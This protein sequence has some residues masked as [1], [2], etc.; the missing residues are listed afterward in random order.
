LPQETFTA[1][2]EDLAHDGR[3]IARLEGK[4]VLVDGALPGE[5]VTFRYTVRHSGYDEGTV[6]T[7]L[8]PAA[9]R[10]EP[11]CTHFGVCGGCG[12][13]HLEPGAQIRFKEAQLLDNLRRIGKVQPQGVLPP[14][15][16]D[17]WGYR[18]KARLGVK[19]V[20]KKGRVLVGFRERASPYIAAL[21]RCEVLHPRVGELLEPLGELI[22]GL[23]IYNRLPQIEVAVGDNAV[24]LSF[25]VLDPPSQSDCQLLTAFGQRHDIWIY[26][27]PKGPETT[28]LLWP[29]KG[30][31]VYRLSGL[32]LELA[33]QPYHFTQVN[34]AIN[35]SMIQQALELLD[36]NGRETVLDLFCGLGNFTLPLAR[37]AARVVGVEGD[38]SL[39][40]WA[41][42]N[43][44]RNAIDN[45]QFYSA[46]LTASPAEQ[47]W[48]KE[49]F[50]RVLLDPPRSGA[51]EMIPTLARLKAERIVYVSCHP[52]T[53]ARDAG[54][55]VNC[56]GYR[57]QRAGV[58]DMFPHTAH[59]E[60]IALF[61]SP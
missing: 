15:T 37:K 23:S 11:R 13:Q 57:L 43:A 45:A 36:L 3:G 19:Y 14:L 34:A 42:R 56:Y 7:I 46:D 53:L 18:R 47:N 20:A 48:L 4:V 41:R 22:G 21:A 59:V 38:R 51:L 31:L 1:R 35:E 10:V 12:L 17:P 54:Q 44:R 32:A 60:S 28:R 58:M 16:A 8:K 24:G 49:D 6:Q 29:E 61:V 40:E 26:L 50:Q 2:I 52:A 55:L 30:E 9:Q 5:E 33:F 27:Q 25:R 39:V